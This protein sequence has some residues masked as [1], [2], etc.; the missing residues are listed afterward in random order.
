MSLSAPMGL[1]SCK[2]QDA[3]EPG[4]VADPAGFAH[5]TEWPRSKAQFG[6]L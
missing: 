3:M 4:R 1:G 6:S 2:A 5:V